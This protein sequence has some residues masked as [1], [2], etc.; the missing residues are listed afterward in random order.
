V[1]TRSSFIEPQQSP[2]RAPR[3]SMSP[4]ADMP[5]MPSFDESGDQSLIE[6]HVRGVGPEEEGGSI[7]GTPITIV[8][9]MEYKY[10]L[11]SERMLK[12]DDGV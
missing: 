12:N 2:A 6:E 4:M 10:K 5:P 3:L 9:K 8:S 7:L 11:L 1:R